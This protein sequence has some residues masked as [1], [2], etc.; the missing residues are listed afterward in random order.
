MVSDVKVKCYIGN[1]DGRRLGMVV[2][3]NQKVAAKVAETS[4]YEFRQHWAAQTD[5]PIRAP[6]LHTLYTKPYNGKGDFQEGRCQLP[7]A[8]VSGGVLAVRLSDE[9]GP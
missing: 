7:N 6:K 8:N 4:V 5:W 3:E 9:L 2:A 1:L